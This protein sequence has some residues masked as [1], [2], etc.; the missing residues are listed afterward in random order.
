MVSFTLE[1]NSICSQKQLNDIAREHTIIC[2]Q[3]FA[4]HVVGSRPM[5][6]KKH[7]YRMI[8]NNICHAEK[9]TDVFLKR[10]VPHIPWFS[11]QCKYEAREFLTC[12]ARERCVGIVYS[13]FEK[14]CQKKCARDNPGR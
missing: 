14:G 10:S 5:K 8:I 6:R 3:L 2:R 7:L 12:E 4:G 1:Q 13:Y 11:C 9:K